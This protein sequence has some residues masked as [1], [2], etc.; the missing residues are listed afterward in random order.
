VDR[1]DTRLTN[2]KRTLE[3]DIVLL[4]TFDGVL[5]NSGLSVL[6]DWS[7]VDGLPL[8]GGLQLI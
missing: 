1:K 4:H 5:G 2:S 3:S 7:D 8:D 6:Q